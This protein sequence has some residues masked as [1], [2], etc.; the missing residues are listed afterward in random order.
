[1][2]YPV[3][4]QD[5]RTIREND[6]FYADKTALI[7]RLVKGGQ[8]YF[9]SR[10]RRFGKSLLIS[11][12]EAYFKGEKEL[13]EGLAI[14]GLEQEW[15]QYP[16]LHLDLNSRDYSEPMALKAELNK[17]LEVWEA[18][19]CEAHSDRAPEE[20]FAAVIRCAYE[21]TGKK[22][23]FLV[24]EYDKPLLM[25][26]GNEKLQDNYRSTLKAFYSVEKS[27]GGYIQM[28]FFTGVTKFSKVSVFSDLNNLTDITMDRRYV[29][30]CGI[31]ERE[32]R[33]VLDSEVG[34]L[35]LANG[36]TKDEC[37]EK[38]K[39]N[40][41]GY[42][43]EHDT[44]GVYNPFSLLHVLDAKAFKD[45]WFETGTP[46]ILVEILKQSCYNL[47]D[48]TREEVTADLLGRIDSFDANPI[49]LLYQSGYLTIKDYDP[50]FTTYLLGFPN[51]EV[52]RGFTR[53]LIPYYSGL[54]T[55]QG[56]MFVANFVK[57]LRA[58]KTEAF[59]QRLESLFASGDYQVAGDAELYFQ[60]A[61]WVIFKM[62][63]FYT[64]V[65]RHT[66]D[67]RMDMLIQTQD[68]I[69]I[70]EFKLDKSAD[71]ALQQIEN[72]LYAKPFEHDSRKLYK[73]GINFSTKTRRIDGWKMVEYRKQ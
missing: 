63:G 29:E 55:N 9:L 52:E 58:G 61:C 42:H 17:H 8:F 66:T 64:E 6:Y 16:V 49:P 20:R 70:F 68:Y 21:K 60:N 51:Q 45:Y 31:T 43:F 32:I 54:R 53:F 71:E 67:G 4:I 24:D 2:K 40:Y 11:T 12:L 13:F 34:E 28:V 7:Y 73:I 48:L 38:L 36:L 25:T 57:E 41:D 15:T 22:V 50:E 18:E 72:K 35:A 19:Y 47:E 3:G 33:Q 62:I 23:V 30:L 69:Y 10:P 14:G 59:M 37:Y 1:M 5:F 26:F 46:T 65:E 39:L 44:V 56:P 27:M